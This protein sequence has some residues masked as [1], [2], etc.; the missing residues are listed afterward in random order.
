MC[1][2]GLVLPLTCRVSDLEDWAIL[3]VP[4]VNLGALCGIHSLI[5]NLQTRRLRT[6]HGLKKKKSS[7]S[8]LSLS[9][10]IVE[11]GDIDT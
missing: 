2:G 1:H 9:L 11:N 8:P 5:P 6:G 10:P 4:P 3:A 7:L